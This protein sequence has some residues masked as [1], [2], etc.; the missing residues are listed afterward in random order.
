MRAFQTGTVTK[1]QL[2]QALEMHQDADRFQK[3]VF[4]DPD[5]ETGCG[6]GCSIHDFAPGAEADHDE[7]ERLFG[8]P[9]ELAVLEDYIFETL[10]YNG[11]PESLAQ[12]PLAFT[13]AIPEGADLGQAAARWIL[14]VLTREDSPLAHAQGRPAVKEAAGALRKWMD[15][16]EA[17]LNPG[18]GA[19]PRP[20]AVD[21]EG[22]HHPGVTAA[23]V[24]FYIEHRTK[25][26]PYTT[27]KMLTLTHIFLHAGLSNAQQYPTTMEG[28]TR[29]PLEMRREAETKMAEMLLEAL[30]ESPVP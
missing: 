9:A 8:I 23:Q 1:D 28:N 29:K 5:S 24:L 20:D 17:E 27:D 19:Q 3:G 25:Q 11:T 22:D 21:P 14:A 6:V 15:T 13:R 12:W 10:D 30:A 2:I 26:E 18:T 4:W 16:G 7:Y